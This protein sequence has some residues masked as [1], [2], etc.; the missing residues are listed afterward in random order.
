MDPLDAK[1]HELLI[2]DIAHALSNMPR[3]AGHL[4]E[5]YSVGQHCLRCLTLAR[6]TPYEMEALLHDAS[7][8]YLMDMPSPIKHRFPDYVL[9]EKNLSHQI[10]ITFGLYSEM[11]KQ[12]IKDIDAFVLQEELAF[13]MHNST[14]V[15]PSWY[16]IKMSNLEVETMFINEYYRLTQNRITNVR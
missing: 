5:F 11:W 15:K 8:A 6:N 4:K 13:L 16:D 1:P 9:A 7:E 3:F 14:D 2:E 12:E 10:D